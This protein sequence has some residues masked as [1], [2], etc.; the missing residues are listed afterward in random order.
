MLELPIQLEPKDFDWQRV[1]SAEESLDGILDKHAWKVMELMFAL[2]R[3]TGS[4]DGLIDFDLD[5]IWDIIGQEQDALDDDPEQAHPVLLLADAIP[6]VYFMASR[7]LQEA[8]GILNGS[9]DPDEEITEELWQLSGQLSLLQLPIVSLCSLV[10]ED[11]LDLGV[12]L[13]EAA[14]VPIHEN[15]PTQNTF[16]TAASPAAQRWRTA[17]ASAP[18]L[19]EAFMRLEDFRAAYEALLSMNSLDTAAEDVCIELF[20]ACSLAQIALLQYCLP[21]VNRGEES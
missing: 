7:L 11:E 12:E 9:V 1:Y 21:V 15:A 5:T 20:R 4:E 14:R 3:M 6:E 17:L 2:E 19:G 13:E 16:G 18:R 8:A 10:W